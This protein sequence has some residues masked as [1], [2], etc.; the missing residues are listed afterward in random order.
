LP[1]LPEG[2]DPADY[3]LVWEDDGDVQ[4]A[5]EAAGQGGAG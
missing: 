5:E 2:A 4:V 3:E 1:P